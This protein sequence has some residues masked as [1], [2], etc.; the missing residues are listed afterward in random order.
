MYP[1]PFLDNQN[2]FRS[3]WCTKFEEAVRASEW[4]SAVKL[5][6]IVCKN[7]KK[8]GE[9]QLGFL[10]A[11]KPSLRWTSVSGDKQLSSTVLK[12]FKT[13]VVQ[14]NSLNDNFLLFLFTLMSSKVK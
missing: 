5:R 9:S 8:D 10:V 4:L 11:V 3:R 14:L 13:F 7:R 12:E 1:I 6:T 2:F